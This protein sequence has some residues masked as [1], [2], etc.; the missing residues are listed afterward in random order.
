[1]PYELSHLRALE[2]EAIHIFREVAAEF[3]RPVLLFS[4]GKDSIVLAPPGREGVLARPVPVPDDARGHGPQLPRGD[5]VPRPARRGARRPPGRRLGPGVDRRGA[6]GR[7]D[8]PARVA[9]PLQTPVPCSTRIEEQRVRRR[10]RRR[11]P[12]RG[13]RPRQGARASRS[14]T[15]S[16]SGTPRTSGPSSGTSTTGASS[17]GEHVRVFPLSN[18]TELDVWQ[19]IEEEELEIPS[20][21]FATRARGLRARRDALRRQP[22]RGADGRRGRRS[23]RRSATARSAT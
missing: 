6:R 8:R 5:R 22:A 14:A 12:R 9:Q 7:G 18:W 3:E 23:R 15:T 20:I 4:G 2:S 1:M 13:A 16:A 17:K 21:Y 19:Y 11:A 10:V